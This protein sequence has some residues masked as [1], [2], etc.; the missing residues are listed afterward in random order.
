M[1]K[2]AYRT[3]AGSKWRLRY[4]QIL[5]SNNPLYLV[6]I[7]TTG[8]DPATDR[9]IGIVVSRNHFEGTDKIVCDEVYKTLINPGIELS[10]EIT[11]I[12]GITNEMI[13]QGKDPSVAMKEVCDF[14]GE[15]ANICGFRTRDFLGPFLDN[16]CRRAG[17][18][19]PL[20][21]SFD[22]VDMAKALVP[23]THPKKA[24]Y[25]YLDLAKRFDIDTTHGMQGYLD[26]FNILAKNAPRGTERPGAGFVQEIKYWSKSYTNTYVFMTTQF[27]KV[28]L[29]CATGYFEEDTPGFFDIVNMD[30]FTDYVIS[31]SRGN[32][33]WDFIKNMRAKNAA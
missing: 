10:A 23:P 4:Q 19:L 30:A 32:S 14:L 2:R 12:N 17:L 29:N 9:I 21:Y 31:H 11:E 22:F 8:L 24:R 26:L 28:R 6:K 27:G 15:H 20:K 25:G 18:K 13:S 1:A 33:I 5:N 3:V 7:D 16:E